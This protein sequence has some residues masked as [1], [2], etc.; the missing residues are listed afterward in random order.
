[1]RFPPTPTAPATLTAENNADLAALL[2][3]KDPFDPSVAAFA[4][5]YQGQ[6]IEFDGCVADVAPHGSYKTRFDYLLAAGNYDP[7]SALGPSFQLSD[8]NYYDF[9]F[10]SESAPDDVPV[11]T[12][13]HIVAK[14]GEYDPVSGNFQ[15]EPVATRVR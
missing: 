15:L 14:V 8:I 13:L 9:H 12:N 6:T 4:A 10:P 7:D 5:T 2:T 3:V 11:G 1:M